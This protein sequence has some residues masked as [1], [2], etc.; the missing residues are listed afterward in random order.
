MEK[1]C[2]RKREERGEKEGKSKEGKSN[3]RSVAIKIDAF[4]IVH[5]AAA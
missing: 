2:Q 3:V 5:K 4:D 1:K